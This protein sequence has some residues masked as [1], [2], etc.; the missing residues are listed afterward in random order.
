MYDPTHAACP[1]CG[2]P[3]KSVSARTLESLLKPGAAARIDASADYQFCRTP[4]CSIVYFNDGQP[5]SFLANEV[6]VRVGQK[7][8]GPPT[9]VCYCFDFTEEQVTAEV[10]RDGDST[11]PT[12]ITARIQAG[13]CACETRNPQGSCCLGNV[14][15][16]V[17]KAKEGI[18]K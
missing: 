17:K 6:R 10:E 7:E 16:V 3:G 18:A 9:P 14:R 11:I 2:L 13:E 8:P 15:A 1:E 12:Q 5:S 4:G